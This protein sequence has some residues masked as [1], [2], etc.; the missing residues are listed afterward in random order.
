VTCTSKTSY[1]AFWTGIDGYSSNS[2]E[3]DGTLAECYH[4]VAHYYTWWEMY[5]TNSIQEV[6]SSV[7]PGDSISASVVR[8]GT[9]YSLS[10][11]DSTHPANSFGT[12]QTCS[13]CVDSSAEWIAEAPSSGGRIL[14]LADFG[15]WTESDATVKSGSTT[16]VIS[17]FPDDELTMVN[18]TGTVKAKPGALNGSGN[19]FTVSWRSST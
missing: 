4:G 13:N 19:G 1:A 11:T 9:T 10:V 7:K 2:V 15:S 16:G 6:G 5:P 18:K 17:T 3:Q 8:T 14:P 12:T